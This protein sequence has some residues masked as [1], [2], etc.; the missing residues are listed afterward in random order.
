MEGNKGNKNE[1]VTCRDAS[2]S[3]LKLYLDD[4]V[5]G[6]VRETGGAEFDVKDEG[7]GGGCDSNGFDA[8]EF[9]ACEALLADVNLIIDDDVKKLKEN[10]QRTE[11]IENNDV[12]VHMRENDGANKSA[13]AASEERGSAG[14][15]RSFAALQ[16]DADERFLS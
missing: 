3:S 11:N 14:G 13:A 10:E 12:H 8:V 6:G 16:E 2:L 5:R 1:D 7:G 9:A 15:V 4:E